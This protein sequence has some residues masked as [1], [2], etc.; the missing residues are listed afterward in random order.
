M[1]DFL[2]HGRIIGGTATVP[3]LAVALAAYGRLGLRLA[4]QGQVPADLA[5]SW[6]APGVAGAAMAVLQPA[7][8]APCHIRLVEQPLPADFAPTRSFGWAAFEITVQDVFNWPARLA[9][10]FDVIGPPRNIPGLPQFVAMQM[11]GPGREMLYLN[12]VFAD[13]PESDL[14]RAQSPCD[15]VFIVILAAPDRAA[16]MAWYARQLGLVEAAQ[17]TIPYT[18]I[19]RAFGLD[20][21]TL[22]TLSMAQIG[23]LPVVEIDDYPPAATPRMVLPGL[24][25]PGNALVT[26]A[27]DSLAGRGLDFITPPVR[28]DG[29]LTGTVRGPAG[30]LLE[31]VAL[32]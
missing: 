26:L 3:D 17:H 11:L 14:A 24:L 6:G 9:G 28:R 27:V 30:E 21:G 32:G 10:A 18:M 29:R 7:S 23:R 2:R 4:H 22:T 8:G 20:A 15:H 1:S 31:L 5:A 13:T 25:P 12:E 16:A 19:N